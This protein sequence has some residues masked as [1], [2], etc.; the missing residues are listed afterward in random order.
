ME[1]AGNE[2]NKQSYR[3]IKNKYVLIIYA[4]KRSKEK[5]MTNIKYEFDQFN[6]LMVFPQICFHFPYIDRFI[7]HQ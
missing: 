3:E 6:T 2:S 1:N 7:E 4:W 5:N